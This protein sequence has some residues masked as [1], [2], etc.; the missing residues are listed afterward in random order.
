MWYEKD[1][2][3]DAY[4][5]RVMRPLHRHFY[6]ALLIAS[7]FNS[8][9]PY[10]PNDDE[11]LWILA[12]A[13]SLEQWMSHKDVVMRKFTL[14]ADSKH[15]Q[16]KRILKDWQLMLD[17]HNERSE[18]GRRG[19]RKAGKGRALSGSAKA[20]PSTAQA[21][22]SSAQAPSGTELDLT[23]LNL[24]ELNTTQPNENFASEK[25][26]RTEEQKQRQEQPQKR[27]CVRESL[28]PKPI[29]VEATATP[30][31]KS[32]RKRPVLSEDEYDRKK[33]EKDIAE[34]AAIMAAAK[35]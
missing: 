12:D 6:R 3:A 16:H 8:E 5:S 17:A 24:T 32:A 31:P 22:L 27:E 23:V 35:K 34:L 2:S 9:R 1:F 14:T 28:E 19:G 29:T 7:C 15:W 10:L 30:T 4:V 21:E 26:S 33:V 20:Q 13:E 25:D 11:Q 18:A